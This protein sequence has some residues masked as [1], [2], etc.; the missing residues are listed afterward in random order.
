MRF[1]R[2]LC[3]LMLLCL[4]V[5][6]LP[7]HTAQAAAKYYITV[8]ITNQIVTVYVN[9]NTS[10]SGIVRQ[11]I[12][13]TGKN[14]TPTPT[15]TFRL[16]SKT[17]SQ[18]RTEWYYFSQYNGYAKW[19]T[20][21]YR[22]ILFHSVLY[23]GGKKGPTSASVNALGSQA[24]H[25]C[26]RLRVDDARWIA[27]N[28]PAGTKVKVFK[29]GSRN[30]DLRS[31]LL[32]AS[33]SSGSQSYNSFMGRPE[34]ASPAPVVK[35]NLSSGKRGDLVAQLQ[36]RLRA[37]GYYGGAVDAKF[38]KTTKA[39]VSA[40]QAAVGLKKTGK[41]NN[42]LW[43]R[44][45]ADSAPIGNLATLSEGWQGPVVSSLQQALKDLKLFN[46]AVDGN[47][48]ADTTAAVATFQK[49]LN[50]PV[51]GRAD[52]ALQQ[53]AAQM[54][55]N[56]KAQFGATE[57]V[58][59]TAE[60]PVTLATINVKRYIR[61][62]SAPKKGKRLAKLVKGA[63]V[64]VLADDGGKW[65]QVQFNGT[66]GYV[67]RKYLSFFQGTEIALSYQPAPSPDP[68]P[69]LP[70]VAAPALEEAEEPALVIEEVASDPTPVMEP[71]PVAE[72]A[73][74]AEPVPVAEPEPVAEAEPIAEPEP[75]VLPK[76]AVALE[77]GARLFAAIG[78]AE[79]LATL[80]AGTALEVRAVEGDWIAV[81]LN[82]QTAWVA[83]NEVT[84]T[85]ELPEAAPEAEPA[86]EMG[87]EAVEEAVEEPVEALVIEEETGE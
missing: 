33:F 54:A 63:Q 79:A 25:G 24:S 87:S 26:V 4:T 52:T 34:N 80:D 43:D 22:G 47:Y 23:T 20:R 21:I 50:L 16:P 68:T 64:K 73:P 9:G 27:Q 72:P 76:Y 39:A 65:T 14:A 8:D 78:D 44:I 83:A 53:T 86:I 59:V 57:Y 55:A 75:V 36:G 40:F 69:S 15:G 7:E 6:A 66:V 62:R 48:G 70:G 18:E 1:K 32:K 28:C 35:I 61:L 81:A 19:A 71:V 58:A 37:L 31:R 12:C 45:F 13:S 10:D 17:Y 82:G 46:G 42:A 41:V 29:S 56:V 2:F 11:M 30:D 74:V 77:G 51:D 85:D 49:D 3:L 60:T 38:G 84:L 67:E 5:V